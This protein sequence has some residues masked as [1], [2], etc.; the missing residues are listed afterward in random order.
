[1]AASLEVVPAGRDSS[2]AGGGV[3]ARQYAIGHAGRPIGP[4]FFDGSTSRRPF[5]QVGFNGI[6]R[7]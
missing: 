5:S 3:A 6:L 4:S 7:S 2:V 1:M